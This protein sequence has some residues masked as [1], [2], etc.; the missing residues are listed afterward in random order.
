[1]IYRSVDDG[2]TWNSYP[3]TIRPDSRGNVPS[4]HMNESGT[5]PHALGEARAVDS[6]S[7]PLRRWE[8]SGRVAEPLHDGDLQ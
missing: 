5:H 8:R 2:L 6:C 7:A 3:F 1:M 4:M